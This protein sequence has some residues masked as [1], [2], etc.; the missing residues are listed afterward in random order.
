MAGEGPNG[1]PFDF[2]KQLEL[3][4]NLEL[5]FT[6]QFRDE[7]FNDGIMNRDNANSCI[8]YQ[9]YKYYV[10]FLNGTIDNPS[11]YSYHD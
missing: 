4:Y 11:I 7:F 2:V 9:F 6:L 10:N 5:H 1:K 3:Y 8:L